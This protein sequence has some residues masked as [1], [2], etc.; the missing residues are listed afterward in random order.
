MST[1][2]R[3]ARTQPELRVV[4][5]QS[6]NPTFCRDL[7]EAVGLL[8]RRVETDPCEGL[9]EVRGIY[10]MAGRGMCSRHEFA[11]AILAL[12]PCRGEHLVRAVVPISTFQMPLPAC[13]P[14]EVDLNTDLAFERFGLKLPFWKES[15]LRALER[16]Q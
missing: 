5:D 3:L 13:R 10:H 6:G 12:D 1:I 7:A 2:L 16:G 15:L 11:E 8:L 4:A 9:R 14:L